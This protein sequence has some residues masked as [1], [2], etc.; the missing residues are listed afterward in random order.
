M[1]APNLKY[2]DSSTVWNYHSVDLSKLGFNKNSNL[3]KSL[4]ALH[5]NGHKGKVTVVVT[6]IGRNQH[7]ASTV[8]IYKGVTA[9]AGYYYP[10]LAE[11]KLKDFRKEEV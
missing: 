1:K 2:L 11:Y 10:R 6:C 5:S 7:S 8:G 3:N 9:A 4:A